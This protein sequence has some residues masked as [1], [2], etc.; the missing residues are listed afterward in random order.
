MNLRHAAV[1]ALVGWYL[2]T[3]PMGADHLPNESAP[4]TQW[5]HISGFDSAKDCEDYKVHLYEKVKQKS[6]QRAAFLLSS[7][8]IASDDPGLKPN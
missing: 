8:C 2:M 4:L 7:A 3:L 1:L 5:T 6:E